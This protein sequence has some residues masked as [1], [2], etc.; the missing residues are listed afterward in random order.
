MHHK[1]IFLKKFPLLATFVCSIQCKCKNPD[2]WY[3][4]IMIL[5]FPIYME[6]VEPK[7]KSYIKF[8]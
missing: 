7:G 1:K 3:F 5:S 8:K 6:E 2:I 4:S